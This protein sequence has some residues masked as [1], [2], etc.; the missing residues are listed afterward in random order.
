MTDIQPEAAHIMDNLVEIPWD[1]LEPATLDALVEEFV[2]R[3][4]TDYGEQ[5]ASLAQKV[6]QV[7][8]GI[9][10]KDYVILFDTEQDSVHIL[11]RQQFSRRG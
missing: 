5:E 2:T 4:G 3:D 7:I 8:A 6:S 10:R 1:A 9:K 11:T